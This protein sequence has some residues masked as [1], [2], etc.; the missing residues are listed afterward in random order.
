M[1]E[2]GRT[3][4]SRIHFTFHPTQGKM[5]HECNTTYLCEIY[6]YTSSQAPF[7]IQLIVSSQNDHHRQEQILHSL[8]VLWK[9]TIL[10]Y[11]NFE[12]QHSHIIDTHSL[13]V[14]SP[15]PYFSSLR[16]FF[17]I[18]YQRWNC[19]KKFHALLNQHFAWIYILK[20]N[21]KLDRTLL[22]TKIKI[23]EKPKFMQT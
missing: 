4:T 16:S 6:Y 22:C 15:D 12:I 9:I 13:A 23:N 7:Y 8:D 5:Y 19:D 18:S 2:K 1:E 20:R 14:P 3:R 21:F 17:S 10:E 11:R